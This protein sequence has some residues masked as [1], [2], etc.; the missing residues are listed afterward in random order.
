MSTIFGIVESVRSL[1]E[2][3]DTPN[4]SK[5]EQNEVKIAVIQVINS[6]IKSQHL[7]EEM[8]GG[9]Q[10]PD[11]T[12][13]GEYDNVAVE[14][15]KGVSRATLPAMPVKMSYNIGIFHVSRTDDI[16]NGFIPFQAGQMQMI[17]GEPLISDVLGQI[18]YEPRGKY[19][20]FG[21]DITVGDSETAINEVY[22]LL[23]VKDISLYSDWEM[24]PIS[25]DMESAVIQGTFEYLSNQQRAN[26]KVDVINKQ[27]A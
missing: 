20:V 4:A 26:K 25:A 5:F 21:R 27:E 23:A 18:F 19:I 11:G 14:S 1:Q 22:M 2:G 9:E 10:I 3:G 7:T 15:Y 16:V 24:L 13:L 12:V 17:S 8:A 6:L